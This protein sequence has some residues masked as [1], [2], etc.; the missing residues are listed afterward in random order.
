[1]KKPGK[2]LLIKIAKHIANDEPTISDK[3]IKIYFQRI[4][5]DLPRGDLRENLLQEKK[6]HALFL[7]RKVRKILSNQQEEESVVQNGVA[8]EEAAENGT[9][10][11]E[12][13]ENDAAADCT[14]EG[15]DVSPSSSSSLPLAFDAGVRLNHLLQSETYDEATGESIS[16]LW[17]QIPK[18]SMGAAFA[19][20]DRHCLMLMMTDANSTPRILYNV[21]MDCYTCLVNNLKNIRERSSPKRARKQLQSVEK[22]LRMFLVRGSRSTEEITEFPSVVD[23]LMAMVSMYLDL[24]VLAHRDGE[25]TVK[26]QQQMRLLVKQATAGAGGGKA[27]DAVLQMNPDAHSAAY[28]APLIRYLMRERPARKSPSHYLRYVLAACR[29][30]PLWSH[31]TDVVTEVRMLRAPK[32]F[33]HWLRRWNPQVTEEL[34]GDSKFK[35][36][37]VT[38]FLLDDADE[39]VTD[40]LIR[41][42]A[43]YEKGKTSA[44]TETDMDQQDE[45]AQQDKHEE[46][47]GV[48]KKKKKKKMVTAV[49]EEAVGSNESGELLHTVDAE[50]DVTSEE[51]MSGGDD[52]D[53]QEPTAPNVEVFDL[54]NFGQAEDSDALE[55]GNGD[56]DLFMIDR[57]RK[58]SSYSTSSDTTE[59]KKAKKAEA[60]AAPVL[61]QVSEDATFFIDRGQKN[62]KK[63]TKSLNEVQGS[64]STLKK[65]KKKNVRNDKR[66]DGGET[67][68]A[69]EE[70]EEEAL[71]LPSTDWST[72]SQAPKM[73]KKKKGMEPSILP[74]ATEMGSR[75]GGGFFIDRGEK[76]T[77]PVLRDEPKKKKKKVSDT[78]GKSPVMGLTSSPADQGEQHTA[79]VAGADNKEKTSELSSLDQEASS[80]NKKNRTSQSSFTESLKGGKKRST[81]ESAASVEEVSTKRKSSDAKSPVTTPSSQSVLETS[82]ARKPS[83]AKSPLVSPASS[84]PMPET[85]TKRKP[86][87]AKSPVTTPASQSVL[88][89][90]SKR[91]PSDVTS[92]VL[93]PGNQSVLDIAQTISTLVDKWSGSNSSSG[94]SPA[95]RGSV[96]PNTIPGD[97]LPK[98]ADRT[99]VLGKATADPAQQEAKENSPSNNEFFVPDSFSSEPDSESDAV[100]V[101]DLCI[102]L[103]TQ[104]PETKE[105]QKDSP[106]KKSPA[107]V[108][109]EKSAH[110]PNAADS[111]LVSPTY[112]PEKMEKGCSQKRKRR[113]SSHT[114]GKEKGSHVRAEE[115]VPEQAPTK[116]QSPTK[117]TKKRK[118]SIEGRRNSLFEEARKNHADAKSPPETGRR[119]S[120]GDGTGAKTKS[121][122]A[123]DKSKT[124]V[125]KERKRKNS[126]SEAKIQTPVGADKNEA[127]VEK[128]RKRRSSAQEGE[129]KT[130][131]KGKQSESTPQDSTQPRNTQDSTQ[132]RKKTPKS[133]TPVSRRTR[134]QRNS[135]L[136]PAAKSPAAE[137]TEPKPASKTAPA[138]DAEPPSR[139]SDV[140][141]AS[142]RPPS[143]KS[144]GT[145]TPDSQ[146]DPDAA[147]PRS[148]TPRPPKAKSVTTAA[149]PPK[150]SAAA[151]RR[152]SLPAN[153]SDSLYASLQKK[154]TRKSMGP[155][156]KSSI[157]EKP[158]RKTEKDQKKTSFTK[159]K[160]ASKGQTR[161]SAE[162]PEKSSPLADRP[163]REAEKHQAEKREDFPRLETAAENPAARKSPNPAPA[164][165]GRGTEASSRNTSPH[166]SSTA[167]KT[168]PSKSPTSAVLASGSPD[169]QT[170]SQSLR[171][172]YNL[173]KS[174]KLDM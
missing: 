157:P 110:S 58:R 39:R 55:N 53:E 46:K 35:G 164:D 40:M 107:C 149:M 99:Q 20:L 141:A 61:A 79:A 42:I 136:P 88:E 9:A 131:V 12:A 100:L 5:E 102:H 43:S 150:S 137:E 30:K 115:Q 95:V 172:G 111:S 161:K 145:P 73:G 152:T 151:S 68:Q 64:D 148:Q 139:S 101:P 19:G 24:F 162:P 103:K 128:N 173:R 59:P 120:L 41:A 98:T 174:I 140:E 17:V 119:T 134:S 34:P 83:G 127:S 154:A 114:E 121:P 108:Q 76:N 129:A 72:P 158:E 168:S 87:G 26:Q 116:S 3:E 109:K 60:A 96:V 63:K 143:K 16:Q 23:L 159:L 165:G 122:A 77:S 153:S 44:E 85:S 90:S 133:T 51:E 105:R 84:Q 97:S 37:A 75:R 124:P 28:F 36:H 167:G 10:A 62:E 57:G 94:G 1:M 144:K 22:F 132:P 2:S 13:V 130:G 82:T 6:K 49:T 113:E 104:T 11:V 86:S 65:T 123:A 48:G 32:G 89:T 4:L 52:T 8:T 21:L 91:K 166:K 163:G 70:P 69:V 147:K 27:F 81:S 118:S 45:N 7:V 66:D 126:L 146:T 135:V 14:D 160:T 155:L 117:G 71:V 92:P 67:P 171:K 169:R 170:R 25:A 156:V 31:L 106:R 38:A 47:A 142:P 138:A 50:D 78:V 125:E 15:A 54:T 80:E 29:F 74:P 33:V 112:S 18:G 56:D 93:S